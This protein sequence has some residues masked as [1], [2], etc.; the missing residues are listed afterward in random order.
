MIIKIIGPNDTVTQP[1]LPTAE[2]IGIKHEMSQF[3]SLKAT[4]EAL[5]GHPMYMDLNE[6][7]DLRVWPEPMKKLPDAT[8]ISVKHSVKVA[9]L[10]GMKPSE[11]VLNHGHVA[12]HH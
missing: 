11:R 1:R 7:T 12:W 6:T 8:G 10:T 5:F 2:E 3:Y 4:M 9:D